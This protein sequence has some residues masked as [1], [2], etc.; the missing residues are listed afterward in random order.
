MH[1]SSPY[2]I[3]QECIHILE[4]HKAENILSLDVSD[5]TSLTHFMIIVTA[6]NNRHINAL[7]QYIQEYGK[8]ILSYKPKIHG[9]VSSGWMLLDLQHVIINIM[10]QET[11]E[12][13]NL[14]KL[15]SNSFIEMQN[16][17]S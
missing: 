12:Y 5:L 15:W 13:Y 11:R 6:N 8:K 10:T 9:E 3:S 1:N 2:E 7:G 4:D 16:S 17:E 14:E